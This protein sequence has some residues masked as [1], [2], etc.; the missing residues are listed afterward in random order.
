MTA[1]AVISGA[2]PAAAAAAAALTASAANA[3]PALEP[4]GDRKLRILCLHGY[5]Q[6]AEVRLLSCSMCSLP[7]AAGL[8]HLATLQARRPFT[9][10]ACGASLRHW[11][12]VFR[13]RIGSMRKALKSRAEFLFLD[14]PFLAEGDAAAVA[15]SGGD[16]SQPGRSWW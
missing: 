6:N 8:V 13:S 10:P 14:A 9:H 11:P 3:A 4:I 16:A 1:Q 2:A 12:Q 7:V 15:E 5:L